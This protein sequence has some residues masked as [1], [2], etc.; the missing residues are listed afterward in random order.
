MR[1]YTRIIRTAAVM[2]GFPIGDHLLVVV[3]HYDLNTWSRDLLLS[4]KS[5]FIPHEDLML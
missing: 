4:V 5:L 1:R 3:P 2:V